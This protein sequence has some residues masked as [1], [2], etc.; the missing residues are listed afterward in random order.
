MPLIHVAA[1]SDSLVDDVDQ[2]E[3][4]KV[5]ERTEWVNQKMLPYYQSLWGTDTNAPVRLA[6]VGIADQKVA[7]TIDF[8]NVVLQPILA[9]WVP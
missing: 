6:Q 4:A 9:P 2:F 8:A 1:E 7:R 3:I 5:Y